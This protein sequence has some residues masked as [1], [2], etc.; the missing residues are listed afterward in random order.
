MC[1]FVSLINFLNKSGNGN[2]TRSE[3]EYSTTQYPNQSYI[4]RSD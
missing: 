4:D 3:Q 1:F 2:K